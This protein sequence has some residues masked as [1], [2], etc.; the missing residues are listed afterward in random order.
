[1]EWEC[2]GGTV[3]M[4]IWRANNDGWKLEV[5]KWQNNNYRYNVSRYDSSQT[6]IWGD[7]G[8]SKCNSLDEAK[9]FAELVCETL[10]ELRNKIQS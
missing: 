8:G 5:A 4:P 2:V 6:N 3:E 9:S 1:M 7:V 10:K